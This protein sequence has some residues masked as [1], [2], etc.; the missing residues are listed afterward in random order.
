MFPY[1]QIFW[2]ILFFCG[3]HWPLFL[4]KSKPQ[5]SVCLIS[6]PPLI[7]SAGHCY[8]SGGP[9]TWGYR[10]PLTVMTLKSENMKDSWQGSLQSPG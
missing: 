1:I 7:T 6:V 2:E 10:W 5:V 9:R 4:G 8:R 3:L